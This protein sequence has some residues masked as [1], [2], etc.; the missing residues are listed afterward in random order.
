MAYMK[1]HHEFECK[2]N[3][4]LYILISDLKDKKLADTAYSNIHAILNC[5]QS[6]MRDSGQ[7]PQVTTNLSKE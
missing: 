1:S 5:Q 7:K 6:K 4:S 3:K 2:I